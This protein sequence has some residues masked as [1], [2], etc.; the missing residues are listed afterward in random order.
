MRTG[1]LRILLSLIILVG[2]A[3]GHAGAQSSLA[4]QILPRAA[5]A[6]APAATSDPVAEVAARHA[7]ILERLEVARRNRE[8]KEN[9]SQDAAQ[10]NSTDADEVELL[11]RLKVL[12]AQQKTA[13][14]RQAELNDAESIAT[15][16]LETQRVVGF[17]QPPPYSF[18][19]LDQLRDDLTTIEQRRESAA[20]VVRSATDA[21]ARAKSAAEE[22]R[23]KRRQAAG[24]RPKAGHANRFLD[25]EA[26][27]ADE[28]EKL[29][30]I[31]L[32]NERLLQKTLAAQAMQLA[33]QVEQ[34]RT[35]VVLTPAERQ[36]KLVELD[37]KESDLRRAR[38]AAEIRLRVASE[39][40]S[41]FD[42]SRD[43]DAATKA[44]R[45]AE[46]A[47]RVAERETQQQT[48]TLLNQQLQ[49]LADRR[50]AWIRRFAAHGGGAT[51][52]QLTEWAAEATEASEQLARERR[53]QE[54][55]MDEIR[56]E[57]ADAEKNQP[58]EDD[59]QAEIAKWWEVK[60]RA[61]VELISAYGRNVSDIEWSRRIH[62]SLLAEIESDRTAW[63]AWFSAAWSGA[64]GVWNYEIWSSETESV[65]IGK[66][67]WGIVLLVVG[68]LVS[69]HASRALGARVLPR[70]GMH[71]GAAA[72]LQSISFYGMVLMATLLALRLVNVPLTLFTFLGG[73]VAI[74]VGFGSQNLVNNFMSGLILLAERP[75]R[76]GDMVEI[77]TLV[78]TVEHIG[79][80]STRIRT[81][82]NFEII[83]P[84]STLLEQNVVNWTLSD[85]RLRCCIPV[86]VAYG[87]PTREV[88]RWLRKAAEEHGQVLDRP[89]PFVWFVGFGDNALEFE[90]HYW[91]QIRQ[92]SERR[93][94]ESD[95]RFIIDQY[96]RE[97][98][99]VIAFPQRDLHI[100]SD[101][102][103]RVQ[104]MDSGRADEEDMGRQAA[105]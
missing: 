38:D 16:R 72:A 89:E 15:E 30:R 70:L 49:R 37:K 92:L 6:T 60:R 43:S 13:L 24:D 84:N 8:S 98:G 20:A 46:L 54:L 40:L 104:L 32:Q 36:E 31:E 12:L 10:A 21:L 39:R 66:A 100:S 81:G 45:T 62:E 58:A 14:E 22:A 9:P 52:A 78:G 103:L 25:L 7:E 4:D 50:E 42:R 95:V 57:R 67:V 56:A 65:T 51:E 85:K 83:V 97:A 29:R 105:A 73:A 48:V 44:A 27:I 5:E 2:L 86:G 41:D 87:S 64:V 61:Q 23:K 68:L 76:V 47:A 91:I 79:A 18:L 96:F 74:G 55:R 77:G 93:R 80:R 99:L 102:P 82:T 69:R 26:Q 101:R 11:K 75:V 59:E 35:H 63:R 33:E 94:I 17:D 28:Q 88:A 34:V 53:L 3:T 19:L 90:L 1:S 71:A